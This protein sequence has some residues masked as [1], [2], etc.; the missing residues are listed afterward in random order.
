M[1]PF[2][3]WGDVRSFLC[4]LAR[5][6]EGVKFQ[7]LS[8]QLQRWDV[9][10]RRMDQLSMSGES[11]GMEAI[12]EAVVFILELPRQFSAVARALA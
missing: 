6:Q 8:L 2:R 10:L 7:K 11:C 4:T 5:L 3:R 1:K 9:W 12:V